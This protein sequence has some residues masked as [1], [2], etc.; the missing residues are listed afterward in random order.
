MQPEVIA[1]YQ[2]KTGEGPLWHPLEKRVYWTDIPN[3]KLFR[4]DPA[5]GQHER[6]YA[7]D[8]VGG[9]T[10][11]SDGSL[12]LFGERGSVSLWRGGAPEVMIGELPGEREGRFND[13]I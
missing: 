1:D 11:Q 13:V 12:L 6:C 7:G 5:T 4:Y 2:C 9:F 10:I 3:G 8:P